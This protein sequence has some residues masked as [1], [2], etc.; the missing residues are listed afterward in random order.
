[1]AAKPGTPLNRGRRRQ[2]HSDDV[3][4]AIPAPFPNHVFMDD[5][6]ILREYSQLVGC[7][8]LRLVATDRFLGKS[9]DQYNAAFLAREITQNFVDA[10]PKKFTLDGVHF[11]EARAGKS[12]R[13]E[14]VGDW[15][16]RDSKGLYGLHSDKPEGPSAGGNAIGL[17]Q[18]AIRYM[19][20]FGVTKFEIYGE[21]D[22]KG[23]CLNYRLLKA[24]DVNAKLEQ[25]KRDGA[26][27]FS[28]RLE[29]DLLVA[30]LSDCPATG[31]CKYVIET[32]NQEVITTLRQI[33]EIGVS[34]TNPHLQNLDFENE[35]GAVKFLSSEAAR[36]GVR[37][38]LFMNGQTMNVDENGPSVTDYWRG[39]TGVTVNLHGID[40][41]MSIDR[42]PIRQYQFSKYCDHLIGSMKKDDLIALL[43]RGEHLWDLGDFKF[44][45]EPHSTT[46]LTNLARKLRWE[47]IND[48]EAFT[49]SLSRAHPEK[50]YLALDGS[51]K[52][53]AERLQELRAEGY[54]LC[55][56][57]FQHIGMPSVKTKVR[58]V[59][60][61]SAKKPDISAD[62][63][64][65]RAIY[66]GFT[67]FYPELGEFRNPQDFFSGMLRGLGEFTSG[68]SEVAERRN[69][70]RLNFKE[71]IPDEL[72]CHPLYS[73]NPENP[74]HRLVHNLRAFIAH[75][76]SQGYVQNALTYQGN[77]LTN[78]AIQP[79]ISPKPLLVAQNVRFSEDEGVF[80]EVRLDDAMAETFRRQVGEAGVLTQSSANASGTE[81]HKPKRESKTPRIL[82]SSLLAAASVAVLLG[83]AAVSLNR[84]LNPH[85]SASDSEPSPIRSEQPASHP[86]DLTRTSA[87]DSK[88]APPTPEQPA[89]RSPDVSN[90]LDNLEVAVGGVA[91]PK[92]VDDVVGA[93]MGWRNS[94]DFYGQLPA[95]SDYADGWSIVGMI[96]GQRTAG[97]N[98]ATRT[99][100]GDDEISK[101]LQ[102]LANK[103]APP[104]D[105]IE[106]FEIESNPTQ[107]QLA[108][109]T[110]LRTYYKIT[111][112][113][114]LPNMFIFSGDGALGVNIMKKAIGL[115][116]A[117]F[118]T[119]FSEAL[120]TLVHEA[121]HLNPLSRQHDGT[122][123]DGVQ[124][125][126]SIMNEREASLSQRL[127]SGAELTDPDRV[128]LDIRSQWNALSKMQ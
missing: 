41:E 50:K 105:R 67:P 86:Q 35:R 77:Y 71:G 26:I 57:E 6:E 5:S 75:G 112:G 21:K 37:G 119:D 113:H 4:I 12:R 109:I 30:E 38:R 10:N 78:Y 120:S 128:L 95:N 82:R 53:P 88:L 121:A 69:T 66:E 102:A 3:G 93:Y 122:F 117:L 115:H 62:M 11:S 124:S 2:A 111:T 76:L 101:R 68:V 116:G 99:K 31:Q 100:A 83:A 60:V 110:L 48:T 96:D 126:F 64:R 127:E 74:Q 123:I 107:A 28:E 32:D 91:P 36:S 70:F 25:G 58:A 7:G 18:T 44:G 104:E 40:Y 87:S 97:V 103:L 59:D 49:S 73:I 84:Y 56:S 42:P 29:H 45:D 19:R 108:Q 79:S 92:P 54:V 14:V 114:D 72:L 13:F 46:L 118:N 98:P 39:P 125:I 22:G 24:D 106:N 17:K 61:H 81:E 20:D 43:I 65:T 33:P 63:M 89:S 90:A 15:I 52:I 80:L 85:R 9:K 1:M 51:L 55:P 27:A 23:W 34:K 47:S 94:G 16:F 8:T